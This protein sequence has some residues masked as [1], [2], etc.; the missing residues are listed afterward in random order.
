MTLPLSKETELVLNRPESLTHQHLVSVINT[1]LA[2]QNEDQATVRILDLGCGNGHLIDFMLSM[3]PQLRPGVSFEVYGLDAHDSGGQFEQNM[4][5]TRT[6]LES[7][8]PSL[9]W[10]DR[11]RFVSTRES[12]PFDGEYFDFVI[13]NQVMEHIK[14]HDF[15][16]S[17][18]RRTLKKDGTS[19]HLFP[20]K[21]CLWEG[22]I[23]MPLV[24]KALNYDKMAFLIRTFARMGFTKRY[25]LDREK[26]GWK[27]IKD[28]AEDMSVVILS[29]TNYLTYRQFLR[30][31]KR[32][33]LIISFMYSKNYI[34]AKLNSFFGRRVYRYR[35]SGGLA[36]FLGF[37]SCK[38]LT[39]ITL[40]LRKR[41]R[42][43]A[44]H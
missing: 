6:H 34:T 2:E 13:S 22:H 25:Q 31:A 10:Q 18:I 4:A 37:F 40:V 12:W 36:D 29:E 39:S 1:M 17:E 3:L 8:H 21:E 30:V 7:R 35:T 38:Y 14:D 43:Q 19:I 16:F 28:F 26:Y 42:R 33:G 23:Y 41:E 32:Q 44:L 11:L 24:H 9:P 5:H 15:V 20:L 27:S